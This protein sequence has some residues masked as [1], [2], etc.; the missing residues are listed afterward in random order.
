MLLRHERKLIYQASGYRQKD[1]SLWN[2]ITDFAGNASWESSS[3]IG[4]GVC[5]SV[6]ADHIQTQPT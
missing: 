6:I 1:P 4:V 3:T 2:F 5:S